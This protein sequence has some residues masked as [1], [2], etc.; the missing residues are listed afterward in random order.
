MSHFKFYY[1][2]SEY[3]D[4]LNAI[5]EQV[6]KHDYKKNEKFYCGIILTI[7]NIKYLAP[8]SSF[9]KQQATNFL[10]E[11]S[12]GS[13]LGCLRLCFMIPVFDDVIE[14]I[15]F[16]NLKD[17][18]YLATVKKELRFCRQNS[19]EIIKKARI[20]YGFGV[21][22]THP[23]YYACCKFHNLELNYRNF[24]QGSN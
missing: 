10:I 22:P 1:V 18:A 5:D 19:E 2:K 3:L 8:V 12:E 20:V 14:E 17:E 24:D 9:K 15:D 11:D 21:N 6:S 16:A 23:L 4:H 7:N 13:T